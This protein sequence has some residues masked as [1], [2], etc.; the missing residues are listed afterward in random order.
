M[1]NYPLH[2]ASCGVLEY[3][4][5]EIESC[6][7][8]NYAMRMVL[9]KFLILQNFHKHQAVVSYRFE[10][11]KQIDIECKQVFLYLYHAKFHLDFG[12][13]CDVNVMYSLFV[14]FNLFSKKLQHVDCNMWR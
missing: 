10:D 4:I 6:K 7:V 5:D 8:P 13:K 12:C 2:N 3:I 9:W 11:G 1:H 14:F